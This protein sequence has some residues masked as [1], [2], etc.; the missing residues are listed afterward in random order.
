MSEKALHVNN[1]F[2]SPSGKT[3]PIFNIRFGIGNTFSFY[4]VERTV[5]RAIFIW[6]KKVINYRE[7][8][9]LADCFSIQTANYLER[10][11]CLGD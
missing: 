5:F 8:L 9:N 4:F 7:T 10:H 3:D 1:Q 2:H 11:N 6:E